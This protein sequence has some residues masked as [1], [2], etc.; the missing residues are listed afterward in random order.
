MGD[1]LAFLRSYKPKWTFLLDAIS[2]SSLPRGPLRAL[3]KAA[4][5]HSSQ[6]KKLLKVNI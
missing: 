4:K 5:N 3:E 2:Y 1:L 6:L